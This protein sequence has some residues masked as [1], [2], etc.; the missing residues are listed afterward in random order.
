M[1]RFSKSGVL[2]V[3]TRKKKGVTQGFL[4]VYEW[5]EGK[6][7]KIISSAS[8]QALEQKVKSKGLPWNVINDEKVK[9]IMKQTTLDVY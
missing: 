1:G 7:R 3:T 6:N 2:N 8:L 5:Y 4:W 9:D